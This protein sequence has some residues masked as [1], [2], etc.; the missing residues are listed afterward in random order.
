M[1][2]VLAEAG[3][4]V[5]NEVEVAAVTAAVVPLKVTALE[6]AVAEKFVPVMTTVAPAI[7]DVGEME[8]IVGAL[9]TV[10]T[11]PMAAPPLVVTVT[12]PVLPPTGTVVVSDVAVAAVTVA[13]VPL[14]F[15]VLPAVDGEKFEPVIVTVVPIGP[16]VGEMAEMEGTGV[17]AVLL[18]PEKYSTTS[19]AVS[20]DKRKLC[21]FMSLSFLRNKISQ[22]ITF[23]ISY[24]T[25]I[26]NFKKTRSWNSF[27]MLRPGTLNIQT[28]PMLANEFQF[29]TKPTQSLN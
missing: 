28:M 22:I 7:P 18:H 15:T 2:P 25:L 21:F 10:N 9:I 1:A 27:F 6:P 24:K 13:A 16:D 29:K 14:N 11:E 23:I 5:V 19:E 17:C 4:V 8:V 20:H 26:F 3:T 12:A